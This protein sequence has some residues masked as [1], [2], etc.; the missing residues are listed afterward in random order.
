MST[1]IKPTSEIKIRLG[2]N[3]NGPI[4]QFFTNTCALHMD[5]YVPFDN[6]DLA[7]TVV[8]NGKPEAGVHEDYIVYEQKY[9][10]YVYKGISK[11]GNLLHYSTHMHESAGPYWD[12][13]MVSAEMKDVVKEVQ[14]KIQKG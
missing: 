2:I 3:P 14:D 4:Q 7:G 5:K 9:A 1:D 6:G 11:N 10:N 8:T 12:R 13:L